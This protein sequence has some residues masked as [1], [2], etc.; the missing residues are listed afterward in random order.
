MKRLTCD[1]YEGYVSRAEPVPGAGTGSRPT[2]KGRGYMVILDGSG[3]WHIQ[4]RNVK[5]METV[6]VPLADHELRP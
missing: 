3:A 2:A 5:N 6:R 4:E 1:L